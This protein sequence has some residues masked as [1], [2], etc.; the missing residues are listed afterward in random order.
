MTFMEII[1]TFLF[2]GSFIYL[3]MS[4]F[5]T[6]FNYKTPIP[7]LSLL[8]ICVLLVHMTN[9]LNSYENN[10]NY[11]KNVIKNIIK[12][13][14]INLSKINN[15]RYKL[16]IINLQNEIRTDKFKLENKLTD[17]NSSK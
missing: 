16:T 9:M 1:L 8:F 6:S 11:Y 3:S 10:V 2:L 17:T 14:D 7:V 12:T 13:Q 5:E 15:N 4:V